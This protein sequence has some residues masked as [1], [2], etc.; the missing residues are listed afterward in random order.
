MDKIQTDKFGR[1]VC[2]GRGDIKE[3][4]LVDIE[5]FERMTNVVDENEQT[6]RQ[7]LVEQQQRDYEQQKQD[8]VSY[9]AKNEQRRADK[10]L[11]MMAKSPELLDWD[12][13]DGA[14]I[15]NGEKIAGS[16]IRD[17]LKVTLSPAYQHISKLPG[18]KQFYVGLKQLHVPE[19]LLPPRLRQHMSS[20]TPPGFMTSSSSSSSPP[21]YKK[22]KAS[23]WSVPAEAMEGGGSRRGWWGGGSG[24]GGG[25]G[26]P[27]TGSGGGGGGGG[28]I[29]RGYLKRASRA[30][31]ALEIL[32]NI[33]FKKV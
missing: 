13:K 26:P 32:C 14:L 20:A 1:L 29:S 18:L 27:R 31:D 30:S 15:Y 24:G 12:R 7:Q 4:V 22:R 21:P 3:Y 5:R 25:G 11:D 6:K 19:I 23:R 16:N 28:E 17:I 9:L 8:I 2:K 10:L 33:I